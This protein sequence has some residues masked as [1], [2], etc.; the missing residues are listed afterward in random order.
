[1]GQPRLPNRL[2]TVEEYLEFEEEAAGKAEFVAGHV[3]AMVGT[4]AR[5]NLIALNVSRCLSA[6]RGACRVFMSDV[7]LQVADDVI[8]YPDVMVFCGDLDPTA[9]VI[10]D[11]CFLVE[12]TSPSTSRIDKTEKRDA[13]LRIP[14]L[15]G[16]LIVEQGWCRVDR[17]WR[18]PSGG[19][20]SA[21]I[22]DGG[23]PVPCPETILMLDEIYEGLAPLTV[24]ELK[25]IGYAVE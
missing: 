8:Y 2:L 22:Q 6:A 4:T 19:W 17:Y 25:A 12:V 7:K 10:R 14:S 23:I 21:I 3:Y 16:Y 1:M 9:V 20:E 13:Y 18:D 5:H 11:P 15:Q 24:T